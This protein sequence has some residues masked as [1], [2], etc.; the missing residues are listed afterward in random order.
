MS[1]YYTYMK[2]KNDYNK[3]VGKNIHGGMML[4]DINE[5]K[6]VIN[7][8]KEYN[9]QFPVVLNTEKQY[10][11]YTNRLEEVKNTFDKDKNISK[12]NNDI[13][14]IVSE[15]NN[16]I[17]K[18]IKKLTDERIKLNKCGEDLITYVNSPERQTKFRYA[19][20]NISV[21]FTNLC[22]VL[23]NNNNNDKISINI[24]GNYIK[25][26]S[27]HINYDVYIVIIKDL[28]NITDIEL[29]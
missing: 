15:N 28:L 4:L 21:G 13:K 14:T 9:T 8:L 7:L 26:L 29:L 2:Y 17:D 25:P 10:T 27:S 1:Y 18:V 24:S 23:D 11:Q 22:S 6:Y 5:R 20:S 3:N 16:N 19:Y 12:F